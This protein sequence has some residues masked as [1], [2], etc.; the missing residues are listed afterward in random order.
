[1]KL[2][3]KLFGRKN[4]QRNAHD[5]LAEARLQLLQAEAAF[6]YYEH[7]TSMLSAR[8]QRLSEVVAGN[9]KRFG[10]ARGVSAAAPR[11]HD[12][13]AAGMREVTA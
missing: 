11:P 9:D 6:E 1:M 8:I 13:L 7:Q 10:V 3:E 5:E 4:A 12:E 2:L